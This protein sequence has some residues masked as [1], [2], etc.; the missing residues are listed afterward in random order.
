MAVKIFFLSY[1]ADGDLGPDAGH[2]MHEEDGHQCKLD[3]RHLRVG[4]A[5]KDL[6]PLNQPR[7][8][9]NFQQLDQP[10]ELDQPH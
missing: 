4:E 10:H 2:E 6:P 9:Q 8:P 1:P 5:N 3:H 7:G